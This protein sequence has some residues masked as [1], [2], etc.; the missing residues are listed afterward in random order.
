MHTKKKLVILVFSEEKKN[1]QLGA[2]GMRETDF[3]IV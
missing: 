1:G 3:C 2:W